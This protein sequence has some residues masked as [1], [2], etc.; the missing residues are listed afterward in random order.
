MKSRDWVSRSVGRRAVM[1]TLSLLAIAAMSQAATAWAD[2]QVV[3]RV[4]SGP[5]GG[6]SLPEPT[7][8]TISRATA[9]TLSS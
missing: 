5:A 8:F 1:V 7:S 9:P 6:N 3:D 4:S 2:H